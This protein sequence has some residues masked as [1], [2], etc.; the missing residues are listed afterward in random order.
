MTDLLAE[1]ADAEAR[2]ARIQREIAQGPCRE[3]GHEWVSRGGRNAGCDKDCSC[4]V[5]VHECAKCHDCDYGDNP[6]AKAVIERC[7]S[8]S[9]GCANPH[10]KFEPCCDISGHCFGR[11]DCREQ[12]VSNCTCCGKELHLI[13]GQ[14]WTWDVADRVRAGD[15]SDA[16]PQ[17][18]A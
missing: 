6:E 17:Y 1:L 7:A 8:D 4:S 12:G 9:P 2:V 18:E 10:C 16:L 11:A 14:W 5:P 3:F 13:D 15:R